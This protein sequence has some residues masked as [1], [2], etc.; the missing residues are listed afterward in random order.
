[1]TLTAFFRRIFVVIFIRLFLPNIAFNLGD[2][3][4]FLFPLS[5][6]GC[7]FKASLLALW[8]TRIIM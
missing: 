2:R 1:M 4:Y 6:M 7:F 8:Q 5:K 3:I